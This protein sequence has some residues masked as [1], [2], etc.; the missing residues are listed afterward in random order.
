MTNYAQKLSRY[1]DLD[2]YEREVISDYLS[3]I[4]FEIDDFQQTAIQSFIKGN[5]VLVAAPTGSGKT[6]VG[7]F[8]L[9]ATTRA[10]QR[11]F[12]TTPIKALSNQK[13]LEL[14]QR[15]GSDRVGLLTGDN[16]INGDAE[17]V[18]MTTEVL[19]NMIYQNPDKLHEL[20]VVV[21]DE[22]HFLAD[23]ERGVVWEEILILLNQS[24]KIVALSA[25][26]SNVEDFGDWLKQVRGS[27]TFVIEEKRPVPLTQVIA[28]SKELIPL[29]SIEDPKRLNAKV[30][31]LYKRNFTKSHSK[32]EIPNKSEI[33]D[34]L[35]KYRLLPAIYFIFSRK[36]CEQSVQILQQSNTRLTS[37]E[38]K[39]EIES[40][41]RNRFEEIDLTILL[42]VTGPR[43]K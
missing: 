26:V 43:S 19:R 18:V 13:F 4:P 41:I 27:C 21:M 10:N 30:S 33:V 34:L 40:I 7:E 3:S 15:F 11:C 12:Y 28:T 9:F 14:V 5:S 42:Q 22:V 38:E 8:A 32:S 24:V 23:K 37:A 20:G 25:T 36:G 17:I 16:S 39:I 1:K 35:Q 6:I 2:S 29:I 31:N